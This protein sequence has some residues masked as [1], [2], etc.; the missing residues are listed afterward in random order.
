MRRLEII[1]VACPNG[2]NVVDS[3]R[4]VK[5]DGTSWPLS[6][7]L[8]ACTRPG[9]SLDIHYVSIFGLEDLWADFGSLILPLCDLTEDLR[10]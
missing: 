7:P 9:R 10:I 3:V 2:H 1:R 8:K 6:L 5:A 4:R